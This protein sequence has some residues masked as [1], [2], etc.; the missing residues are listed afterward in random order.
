MSREDVKLAFE[1]FATSKISSADDLNHINSFGFRGEALPS[2]AAVSRVKV[3]TRAKGAATGTEMVIEGGA[4]VSETETSCREGTIIEVR[5]LF[6]NTPAR[7]KFM[8]GETTE[9]GHVIDMV[10][11]FALA[12]PAVR[13]H[14]KA[15][16]RVL[17]DLVPAQKPVDRSS[18][19]FNEEE[20]K[21]LI[22]FDGKT[23]GIRFSGFV[24]KPRATR[25]NRTG[26]ILF[27]NGRWIRSIQLSYAIQDAFH[28]VLMHGQYP[29]GAFFLDVDRGRVDVNVHPTKQEVRISQESEIKS[30]IRK[31]I[32]ERFQKESDLAPFLKVIVPKPG[33]P[34]AAHPVVSPVRHDALHGKMSNGVYPDFL[35]NA[36]VENQPA[37]GP[38]SE[39]GHETVLAVH[40]APIAIKNELR[41]TKILGQVHRVFIVAET[42]AG[43]VIIDQ[44]AAHERVMFETLMKSFSGGKPDQQ[45]LLMDEILNLHPRQREIF[46]KTLP[47][48]RKIGFDIDEFGDN[49]FVVRSY[50]AALG[51][52]DV[53]GVLKSFIE[54][55]EEG[56]LKTGLEKHQEEIAALIACQERSVKAHDAMSLAEAE[57][58]LERLG[59]CENPFN[60]PHGRPTFIKYSI[61]DLEK[62]FKRK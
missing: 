22:E 51:D 21:H 2:I 50:P 34:D 40:P 6:F 27:V 62:Q 31:V 26:L 17:L 37:G 42:D 60:C 58:L 45:G 15:G 46:S 43:L 36:P 53:P 33:A 28:G 19:Y 30:F 5:D 20:T 3:Q 18:A 55:L 49:S 11:F 25:A 38:I 39:P 32:I 10:S 56:K 44:H 24:G 59:R 4:L 35:T 16:D 14:L 12:N 48:L 54:E 57:K 41:V 7:R 1:R 61:L 52:T 23:N 9:L 47:T 8:K 29:I 13:F